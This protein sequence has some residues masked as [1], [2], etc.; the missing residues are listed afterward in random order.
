MTSAGAKLSINESVGLSGKY[1]VGEKWDGH[2]F[3]ITVDLFIL[4]S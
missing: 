2:S 4:V 1:S 3:Y